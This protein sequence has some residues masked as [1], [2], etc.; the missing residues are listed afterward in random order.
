LKLKNRYGRAQ[1]VRGIGNE[2]A[3]RFQRVR[4]PLEQPF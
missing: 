3:L 2:C 1:S 4:Q